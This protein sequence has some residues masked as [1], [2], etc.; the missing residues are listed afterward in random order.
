MT[1]NGKH[2]T[3]SNG[4]DWGWFIIYCCF[5]H[6]TWIEMDLESGNFEISIESSILSMGGI[7][8]N[9]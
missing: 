7:A 9:G 6:L 2:T 3:D 8:L 1:G 4:D 5:T